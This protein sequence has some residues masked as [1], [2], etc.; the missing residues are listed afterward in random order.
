[1]FI[2]VFMLYGMS[3]NMAFSGY[4]PQGKHIWLSGSTVKFVNNWLKE[5]PLNLHFMMLESPD[6]VEFNSIYEREPYISYPPGAIVPPYLLAKILHKSYIQVGFIKQFLKIKFFLDTLLVCFIFFSILTYNLK[7]KHIKWSAVTAAM[8]S[9]AW[10]LLPINL[11]YMRNVYFSDQCII[12]VVLFYILLEIYDGCF[13]KKSFPVKLLYFSLKFLVSLYGV[14]TDY[15][16]L[17]VLFI[18]WLNKIVPM[19]RL[20][21]KICDIIAASLIYILPVFAGLSLFI[22]QISFVPEFETIIMEKIKFRTFTKYGED[23]NLILILKLFVNNYTI[24]GSLLVLSFI[25]TL[26]YTAFLRT[27]NKHTVEA[28]IPSSLKKATLLIYIPPCLQILCLQNHSGHEFSMMK[29]ALPFIFTIFLIIVAGLHKIDGKNMHLLVNYENNNKC[30]SVRIPVLYSAMIFFSIV[31]VVIINLW[32]ISNNKYYTDR[33]GLP[34]DFEVEHLIRDNYRYDDVYFSFAYAIKIWPPQNLSISNKLIYKI[35][36]ASDINK[37][38]PHLAKNARLL[39]V[40]SNDDH[41]KSNEII[42]KEKHLI[43]NLMPV[44]KSKNYTVYDIT[45]CN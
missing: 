7:L 44:F 23:D 40:V 13:K 2:L 33:I 35:D 11:Y 31:F 9:F 25:V 36:E 34:E 10:M 6:S 19:F 42:E 3:Y 5:G 8:L 18:A 43:N 12:T 45:D 38:F 39:F 26:I 30:S 37:L 4:E 21:E 1:M 17:F 32:L 22:F 20:R 29:L 16:F 27:K 14:L 28:I 41:D 24:V 15:Y